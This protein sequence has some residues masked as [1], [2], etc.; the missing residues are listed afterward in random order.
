MKCNVTIMIYPELC[1]LICLKCDFNLKLRSFEERL[2]HAKANASNLTVV[3]KN[4]QANLRYSMM[5]REL[6]IMQE[7]QCNVQRTSYSMCLCSSI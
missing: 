1:I 5:F 7:V 3:V 6:N 4:S 2:Q